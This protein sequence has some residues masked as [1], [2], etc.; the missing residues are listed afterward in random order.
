MIYSFDINF[1]INNYFFKNGEQFAGLTRKA[2][3][4]CMKKLGTPILIIIIKA[5]G[6]PSISCHQL[7]QQSGDNDCAFGN[8]HEPPS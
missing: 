6:S 1:M 3:N 5:E 7:S 8:N 4:S 2:Q